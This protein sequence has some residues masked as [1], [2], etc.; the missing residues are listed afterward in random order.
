VPDSDAGHPRSRRHSGFLYNAQE[1]ATA[2]QHK[3]NLVAVVFNDRAYGNVARDLDEDWGGQYGSELH[4]PDFM[5]LSEA[6]GLHG[7]RTKVPTDVGRLVGEAIAMDRPVLIEV[8]VAKRY[9]HSP[10]GDT[11]VGPSTADIQESSRS[12]SND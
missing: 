8:P 10:V 9:R 12:L 6:F 4:N 1:M 11:S 3:I 2:V 7:M 5:K